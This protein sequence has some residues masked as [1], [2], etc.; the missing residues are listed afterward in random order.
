M[1]LIRRFMWLVGIQVAGLV[2]VIGAM[3]SAYYRG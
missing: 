1:T 2:G 3:A